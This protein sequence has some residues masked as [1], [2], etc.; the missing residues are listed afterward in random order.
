[1]IEVGCAHLGFTV[2]S[3][4][5]NEIRPL[6]FLGAPLRS[7]EGSIFREIFLPN[8]LAFTDGFPNEADS[9]PTLGEAIKKLE[10]LYNLRSV[11]EDGVF[12]LERDEFFTQINSEPI[13]L[14]Y[15]EQSSKLEQRS[16]NQDFWKRKLFV[17]TKD[18]KDTNTYDDTKGHI[19]EVD[20]SV[21]TS[22]DRA[23]QLLKGL[24]R[25]NNPFSLGTRKDSLSFAEK[26]LKT[27][28]KAVDL[29]TGGSLA[30][31]INN[32]VGVL[33]LS[34]QYFSNNKLLWMD[35][36]RISVNHREKLSAK[37]II[38]TYHDTKDVSVTTREVIEDMPIRMTEDEF[39]LFS[40]QNLAKLNNNLTIKILSLQWS[41]LEHEASCSFEV[42][43]LF[44][45][46]TTK[47]VLNAGN[48]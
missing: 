12:K 14:A 23:I 9:I 38:N 24:E 21:T 1:L 10:E 36:N 37:N 48:I 32:R 26:S 13:P 42:D 44:N 31:K 43:S 20:T 29:F 19:M 45:V 39:L 40:Q 7:T 47:T 4:F 15:N 22:P 5:L 18:F 6:T 2:E 34:E 41:E 11:V 27:L 33:Q 35:G 28:A 17:W 46:N 25:I 3:N 16:F 8:T 30:S